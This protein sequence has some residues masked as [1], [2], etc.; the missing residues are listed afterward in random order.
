LLA[1]IGLLAY[2]SSNA[3]ELRDLF[4]ALDGPELLHSKGG[5]LKEGERDI[6]LELDKLF[7]N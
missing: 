1:T 7:Q 5:A 6:V 2:K 4:Q 3:Q